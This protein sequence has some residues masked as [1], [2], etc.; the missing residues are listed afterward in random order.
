[1]EQVTVL[2]NS[3]LQIILAPNFII[4][5]IFVLGAIEVLKNTFRLGG[6]AWFSTVAPFIALV[7]SFIGVTLTKLTV[8][9]DWKVWVLDGL[10]QAFLVDIFY[11]FFGKPLLKGI[12]S[13]WQKLID[14][15]ENPKES[16]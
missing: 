16:D 6:R 14:N 7:F 15:F 5:S 9:G 2:W 10:T 1:M 12:T 3:L 8:L 4:V 13:L 11:T